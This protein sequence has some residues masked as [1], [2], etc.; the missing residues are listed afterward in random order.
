M[1]KRKTRSDRPIFLEKTFKLLFFERKVPV[2]LKIGATLQD[3]ETLYTYFSDD[4]ESLGTLISSLFLHPV[5]N[6][7]LKDT[8]SPRPRGVHCVEGKGGETEEEFMAEARR[9][10]AA[11]YVICQYWLKKDEQPQFFRDL[12]QKEKIVTARGGYS[13]IRATLELFEEKFGERRRQLGL[14]QKTKLRGFKETYLRQKTN[15]H[16]V[17]A[18][19]F[20]EKTGHKLTIDELTDYLP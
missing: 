15:P 14:L 8:Y 16:L 12:M 1:S 18:Q 20:F 11:A 3:W 17:P 2:S 10:L 7:H 19:H 5:F 6:E 4:P 9:Y 13:A